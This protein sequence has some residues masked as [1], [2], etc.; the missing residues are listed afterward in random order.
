MLNVHVQNAKKP[1]ISRQYSL[2]AVSRRNRERFPR[3]SETHAHVVRRARAHLRTWRAIHTCATAASPT[4]R[5]AAVNRGERGKSTWSTR[6]VCLITRAICLSISTEKDASAFAWPS[7]NAAYVRPFADGDGNDDEIAVGWKSRLHCGKVRVP[8]SDTKYLDA[9][10]T[11][12]GNQVNQ[13][14]FLF[15]LFSKKK[16]RSLSGRRILTCT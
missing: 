10:V 7:S 8:T 1:T 2:S 11:F 5:R 4:V 12:P 3:A 15:P 16:A 6:P 9:R 14:I 13:R